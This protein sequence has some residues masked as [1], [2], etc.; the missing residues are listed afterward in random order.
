MA[1][2]HQLEEFETDGVTLTRLYDESFMPDKGT[3]PK[4]EKMMRSE[5]KSN[6]LRG[7]DSTKEDIERRKEVSDNSLSSMT[8]DAINAISH[9]TESSFISED[10]QTD[11]V[12]YR[13]RFNLYSQV[14]FFYVKGQTY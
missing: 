1:Q 2:R 12:D 8:S 7:F 4:Y 14:S 5:E 13:K 3:Y 10:I 9:A 6:R 11:L